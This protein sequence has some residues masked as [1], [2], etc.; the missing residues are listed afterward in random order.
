VDW[1]L[2]HKAFVFTTDR[3]AAVTSGDVSPYAPSYELNVL[4]ERGQPWVSL[5]LPPVLSNAG[6]FSAADG[7]AFLRRIAAGEVRAVRLLI[8]LLAADSAALAVWED[9]QLLRHKT[10]TGYTVR[11]QQGGSQ[12]KHLR[13]GA[14]NCDLPRIPAKRTA[15]RPHSM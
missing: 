12:L 3:S 9:G 15:A 14:G 7:G 8:A 10:L 11:K 1:S 5:R 6:S 13:S 4:P 2:A